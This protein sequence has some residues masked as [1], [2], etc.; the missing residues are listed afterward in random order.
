[1]RL[2]AAACLLAAV[3]GCLATPTDAVADCRGGEGPFFL[4][5]VG[6]HDFFGSPE[7]QAK[8]NVR[9]VGPDGSMFSVVATPRQG[10]GRVVGAGEVFHNVT[11]DEVRTRLQAA[12]QWQDGTDY[13]VH[14]AWAARLSEQGFADLCQVVV[15]EGDPTYPP[16]DQGC[17]DGGTQDLHAWIRGDSW[18]RRIGCLA[19][20]SQQEYDSGARLQA[21]I[22]K[23]AE[24]AAAAANAAI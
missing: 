20:T 9:T 5:V 11:R 16:P 2:V 21:A 12:G 15:R 7:D 17:F 18:D 14:D 23:A 3:A 1:V 10:T 24:E 19:D 6:N 22:A 8:D 4:V 13:D